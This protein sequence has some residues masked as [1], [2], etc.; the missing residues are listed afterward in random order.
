M[1]SGLSLN[2]GE[3]PNEKINDEK[4][5]VNIPRSRKKNGDGGFCVVDFYAVICLESCLDGKAGFRIIFGFYPEYHPPLYFRHRLKMQGG[6]CRPFI[7]SSVFPGH[8]YCCG[9]V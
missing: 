9:T 7:G 8:K 6:N 2:I 1:K 3:K 5:K 4:R